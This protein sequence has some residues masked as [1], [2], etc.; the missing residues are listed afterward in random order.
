MLYKGRISEPEFSEPNTVQNGRKW[1]KS[2]TLNTLA[3]ESHFPHGCWLR[4]FG[5]GLYSSG[6]GSS[7]SLLNK[8][9]KKKCQWMLNKLLTLWNH[10]LVIW[11]CIYTHHIDVRGQGCITTSCAYLCQFVLERNKKDILHKMTFYD[12]VQMLEHSEHSVHDYGTYLQENKYRRL[13][14]SACK[15]EN[16]KM[17]NEMV[18]TVHNRRSRLDMKLN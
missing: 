10:I 16:W 12:A 7:L 9:K 11:F 15:V 6:G 8:A 18:R 13:R 5:D 2:E 3:G 1:S 4:V 17:S 14:S